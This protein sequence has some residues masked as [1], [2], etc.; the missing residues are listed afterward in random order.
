M[1]T[2]LEEVYSDPRQ[3]GCFQG[4]EKVRRG[5]QKS[6]DVTA[7][8]EAVKKW[9]QQK[10]T[11][12]KYR[13]ARRSFKRNPVMAGYIDEQWQGDLAD[14]GNLADTNDDVKFL[15]VLIDIVS[16]YMW[17]QA[18]RSKSGPDVL[19]GFKK[20]F[21]ETERRPA[22]LQTDDGNEFWYRGLQQYLKENG[23]KFF[24]LK[25]D[26]KAA[27]AERVV[28]TLKEK[29]W[30]YM[31][32]KHTKRYIDVLPDLVHSYNNTYHVSIGL[33]PSEVNESNEGLV[34]RNLYG[35]QWSNSK[36]KSS[37][38]TKKK[39]KKNTKSSLRVGDLVRIS[40][41]KGTFEKGYMGNWTVEI[42]KIN[43]IIDSR[44]YTLYKLEDLSGELIDG[45]FYD[46]EVQPITKNLDGFWNVEKIL[47]ERTVRRR[48]QYFVKWEGYPASMNSW[49]DE[50]D[51][52]PLRST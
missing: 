12:T 44:P 32:E 37:I 45:S 34:L 47:K 19:E 24:T 30:R 31:H 46:H 29:I 10:D 48:K 3:P 22:K 39:K 28:R 17:V 35:K 18:L 40:K 41:V 9:L 43:K 16:K 8:I 38:A 13:T 49:V 2:E 33:A 15:L 1:D 4:P 52:K 21:N 5:L 11:Y 14:M 51:I 36:Q 20:V 27:V 7:S 26:K 50:A 6:K 42:F 23:V 25:S